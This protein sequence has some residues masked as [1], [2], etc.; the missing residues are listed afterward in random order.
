VSAG[1][2]AL[3]D[4][5]RDHLGRPVVSQRLSSGELAFRATDVPPFGSR[6]YQLVAVSSPPLTAG[7][8]VM[9]NVLDSG[10]VRVEVDRVSGAVRSLRLKELSH[11]FVDATAPVGLNDYRYV[12][13]TNSVG[14][15]SNGPVSL[16]VLDAGP[17]VAT[18]RIESDAPGCVRLV[19]D[20]RVVAGSDRVEFINQVDRKSVRVKDGVHFGFGFNV[21]GGTVRM[22]TPWAIVRPNTDQLRGACRNW[23]TVQRWVDVSAAERGLQWASLDAPLMEIGGLTANLLGSVGFNE[24][25]TNAIDSRTLYSWAQN[26]HW[27]TNYKIDQPGLTTFR[28]VVR[29]HRRGYSAAESMRFGMETSRPLVV[30]G[31][32]GNSTE[33]GPG[34]TV[35]SPDVVVETIKVSDDGQALIVR[36]FGAAD[37]RRSVSLDWHHRRP[38]GVWMTD[39]MEKPLRRVSGKLEV[40]AHGLVQLRVEF[41]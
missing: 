11:E 19:R 20:V 39:L 30:F 18:L 5:V 37:V 7:T 32:Q 29:P 14:A 16:R 8:R 21:P 4:G 6:R 24:W 17:L 12:L 3:G 28:Y 10:R 26:N 40:P 13:G 2:A 35:S 31:A 1:Q 23:F 36:L 15:Q 38:A 33:T 9:G 41:E 34:L 27:H 25:L 22:E